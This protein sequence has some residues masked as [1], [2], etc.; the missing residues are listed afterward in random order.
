MPKHIRPNLRLAAAV[1]LPLGLVS[2][3]AL[4]ETDYY[5]VYRPDYPRLADPP[6]IGDIADYYDLRMAPLRD[7]LGPD[8]EI[9]CCLSSHID[10]ES[11]RK[12]LQYN[13][14]RFALLP[15]KVGQ[16]GEFE[17]FILDFDTEQELQAAVSRL[18]GDIIVRPGNGTGIIRLRPPSPPNSAMRQ[19]TNDNPPNAPIAGEP[20]Q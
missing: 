12:I 5:T 3:F 8:V 4:K 18:P 15:A 2:V 7:A 11:N 6:P 20:S 10:P 16:A 14:I 1:I 13:A 19:S 17:L 9:G